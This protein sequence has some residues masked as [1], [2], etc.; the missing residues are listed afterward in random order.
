MS[1]S[2]LQSV[3]DVAASTLNVPLDTLTESSGPGRPEEWDSMGQ[4][5][6]ILALEQEFDISIPPEVSES[7]TDVGSIV[8]LLQPL[9][10]NRSG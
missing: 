9:L 7:M 6:I 3:R 2:L 1:A 5:N 8:R 4:L 10:V